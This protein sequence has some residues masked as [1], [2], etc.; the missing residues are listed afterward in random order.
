MGT[1]ILTG[2]KV[3]VKILE[4]EKIKDSSDNERVSREIKILKLVKHPNIVQ[5]YEIIETTKELFLIMELAEGGE[6]FDYIVARSRLKEPEACKFFSQIM[7]GVEYLQKVMVVHRDLKPENLLID[8]Q[9][10]IK[11]VDFG[12]SNLYKSGET[13][14]TACGSPCYAAP[15]MIAGKRYHGATVDVWSC[16]VI[17]FAMICGYLPF[18]DPNTS[19]LYKKILTADYRCPKWVSAEAQDLL[20]KI[21]NTDPDKRFTIEM[22]RM[23]SWYQM[24][25]PREETILITPNI[26]QEDVLKSVE[27]LGVDINTTIESLNTGKHNYATAIYWLLLKKKDVVRPKVPHPPSKTPDLIVIRNRKT[28]ESSESTGASYSKDP[29]NSRIYGNIIK[30][31]RPKPVSRMRIYVQSQSPNPPSENRPS[32]SLGNHIPKQPS[33]VKPVN[34]YRNIRNFYSDNR[35]YRVSNTREKAQFNL[36]PQLLNSLNL[37]YQGG[38]PRIGTAAAGRR[39]MG[40]SEYS[41]RQ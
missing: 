6:L 41:H 36:A 40:S 32:T 12:L 15:E 33:I 3:A 10:N 39:R 18:E 16:G 21:L 7:L 29:D 35:R 13:L 9:K 34:D 38:S 17:L 37:S 25:I 20:K 19:Q 2:S 26:I 28:H 22:I 27:A 23:H 11:I 24:H 4:K 14:K 1:H 5:L 30:D 31:I 8:S